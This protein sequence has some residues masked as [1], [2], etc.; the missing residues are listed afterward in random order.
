MMV[1]LEAQLPLLRRVL[2][3]RQRQA[4]GLCLTVLGGEYFMEAREGGG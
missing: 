1:G 3:E 2:V 4:E